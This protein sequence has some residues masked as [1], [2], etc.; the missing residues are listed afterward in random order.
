ML[1]FKGLQN[2]LRQLPIDEFIQ[3]AVKSNAD[4]VIG[5]NTN[6]QL[7][8]DGILSNDEP[9]TPE[10][11][12]PYQRF[13]QRI[14][15]PSDRVTLRL[16]GEFHKSFKVRIGA[17]DFEIYATDPKTNKL[18]QK[19]TKN[20]FGLTK[21]NQQLFSEFVLVPSVSKMIKRKFK[22]R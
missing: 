10:Y 11:S 18:T 19:Y 6:D 8:K 13:K 3:S 9:V 16:T 20:I 14:N 4:E 7:Y 22:I 15:Q 1:P 5:L 2:A 21:S 17:Q 12:N